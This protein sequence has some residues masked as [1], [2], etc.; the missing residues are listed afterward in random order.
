MDS[1]RRKQY[2]VGMQVPKLMQLEKRWELIITTP[3]HL[4]FCSPS[5]NTLS[6]RWQ[7]IF[8]GSHWQMNSH[9]SILDTRQQLLPYRTPQKKPRKPWRFK[10]TDFMG[11]G[12]CTSGN[13]EDPKLFTLVDSV[14]WLYSRF[15]QRKITLVTA[16]YLLLTIYNAGVCSFNSRMPI[17][18]NNIILFKAKMA[19]R[20]SD[21]IS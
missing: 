19:T 12:H 18:K 11:L 17:N 6:W 8:T 20:S 15:H 16:C 2:I 21:S 14:D 5:L 7:V 1:S 10:P 9:A 3:W 13:R 4:C